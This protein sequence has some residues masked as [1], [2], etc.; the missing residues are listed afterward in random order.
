[1]NEKEEKV[2]GG[3]SVETAQIFP[4]I[5]KWLYSDK[6][7]FIREIISNASDACTKLKRLCSLGQVHDIDENFMISVK[8]DKD[9]KTITV[10]DNGIGMTRD[11]VE[12]YICQI[13]LSGAL[14]FIEKYESESA[15]SGIIGH[16]GLGFYSAFMVCD[17]VELVTRSYQGGKT[18]VWQ[19]DESGSYE[20]S[21][22]EQKE[23]RGTDV[24]MHINEEGEEYLDSH[25]LRAAI[26]KYCAF[27]PIPIYFDDGG[28]C[29]CE[30]EH[31]HKDGEECECKHSPVQIN[32][33][34]PLWQKQPSEC[35]DEEYKQFYSKVFPDFREPLFWIHINADYPL[36]FKGILY[37]PKLAH[38]YD[39]LEG[40]VKL[41]YNQ[42]FVADNIKEVIPEYLLMLRG[43]LD[44]PEL[45]LNVSRS[46]LQSNGYVKKVSAHIVKKVADKI[47]GMFNTDREAYEKLWSEIK[48]FCEYASLCDRKFFDRVKAS[49][50]LT[51]T[52]GT[53]KTLAEYLEAAKEKHEGKVFY[54]TN[55]TA[56]AQYISMLE[57]EG[58][59]CAVFD[60]MIDT[61]FISM[62]ESENENVKF[63]RVDSDIS[64]ILR[65][66]EGGE[67]NE[68]LTALFRKVSANEKLSVKIEHLKDAK[69]PAM[70]ILDEQSRRLDD[71]MKMYRA[72]GEGM[73]ADTFA[74]QAT[75][76]LN[77][78]CPTVCSLDKQ[79]PSDREKA[80][81]RQIYMLALLS[82]RGL[83]GEELKE[84]LAS[85]YDILEKI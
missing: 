58:I 45:P 40:Q 80:V 22:S 83:S 71:M 48:M 33:T 9:A 39:S 42:V 62:L 73:G 75:L 78:D 35:T 43:V 31:K 20:M 27:M 44:C 8:L 51:L 41:Y 68:R 84:F 34:A 53:H 4:V 19:C 5:K 47:N 69:L 72:A 37:F 46:Y 70:L 60:K 63:M 85:S 50:L 2:Q 66:K 25:T 11:E 23:C 15:D 10:S 67:E 49:L 13:A 61:Q 12:R 55:T 32:D 18:V 82:Q 57:S 59:L 1:M 28:V 64:D 56:Q 21:E 26:D 79:E 7:I 81:A 14:E 3:I 24:I 16:F 54:A 6:E 74:P 30:H 38:E 77:L 36:N 65:A 76:L 29:E 17:T 52:D